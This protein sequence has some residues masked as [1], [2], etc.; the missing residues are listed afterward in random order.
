MSDGIYRNLVL[1]SAAAVC[2]LLAVALIGS[3]A[4]APDEGAT[5]LDIELGGA[6]PDWPVDVDASEQI[7]LVARLVT[8]SL[9][10]VEAWP[11]STGSGVVVREDGYVVTNWHVVD[12]AERIRVRIG[13]LPVLDATLVGRDPG[14]DLA[15][16]RVQAPERLVAAPLGD[17]TTLRVGEWVVA[18]GAPFGLDRTVSAGIVSA[19]NRRVDQLSARSLFI[20]TDAA[21]N[22]GNSGGPLVNLR[23]EVVG[24]NTAIAVTEDASRTGQGTYAGV[25]FAIPVNIVVRVASRLIGRARAAAESAEPTGSVG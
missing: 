15:V 9:A 24:I 21:I 20:Q 2:V 13:E 19:L 10:V 12:G 4:M 23:G 5:G 16:L 3:L 25:G 8:P 18:L 22:P 7:E 6:R 1:A 14:T 17:S 11:G